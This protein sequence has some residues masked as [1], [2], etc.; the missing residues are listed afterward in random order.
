MFVNHFFLSVCLLVFIYP[1][2]CLC[3]A[4][5]RSYLSLVKK[6][7]VMI[8]CLFP[9]LSLDIRFRMMGAKSG[10]VVVSLTWVVL[11]GW[12]EKRQSVL[13]NDLYFLVTNSKLR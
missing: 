7:C 8:V 11:L 5:R 2:D 13:E 3:G 4:I 6:L 10:L 1:T 12:R 9:K